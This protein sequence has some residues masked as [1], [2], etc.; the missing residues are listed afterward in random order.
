VSTERLLVADEVY[1][2][3][4]EKFVKKTNE[5]KLG[6]G[7]EWGINMGS[8]ISQDQLDTVTAH[9]NDAVAKGAKV[10]TG[11]KPRPDI[12]PYYYEPTILADVTPDMTCFGNETFGPVISVYR[13]TDEADA[14][15]RANDGSYGLNAAVFS[16]D[17]KRAREVA[18]QIKCGTVNINEAYAA[19]FAS[20]EAPMG[21]MRES[22]MGRRQGAEGIHRY[23]EVQS[24][25]TQRVVPV[26]PSFGMS[27]E[28]WAKL[29]TVGVRVLTKLGRK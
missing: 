10:L 22:G 19:T 17:G 6:V 21:G 9:V 23:T 3:F 8:L 29:M 26:A 24:V 11:G 7:L 15:A 20:I 18:S 12:G 28:Q 2:K 13:F 5:M 25:G 16:Q 1:D 4:V 27:D 14:I